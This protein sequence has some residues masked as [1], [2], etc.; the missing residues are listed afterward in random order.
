MLKNRAALLVL[1]AIAGS[2]PALPQADIRAVTGI[3]TDKRGNALPQS[4]VQL[5]NT[6]NLSV[7]SYITDKDGRYHFNGLS[8]EID[9]KLRA[10][11]R[12]YWSPPKKLSKFNSSAHPE[13]ELVIPID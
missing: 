2:V 5:E 3:V 1:L 7:I 13:I 10:H 6:A 4:V 8:D 11:Y 12:K 9:Y